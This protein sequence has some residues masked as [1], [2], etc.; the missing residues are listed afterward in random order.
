MKIEGIL[1]SQLISSAVVVV[2]SSYLLI[3]NFTFTFRWD[4]LKEMLAYSLPLIL[5]TL[6]SMILTLSD[7]YII[8]YFIDFSELG[9]YSLGTKFA[10]LINVFVLQSFQL[11]FLPIAFKIF[12]KPGAK[13]FLAKITTYMVLLLAI[14]SLVI[15]MFSREIIVVASSKNPD[16]WRASVLIPILCMGFVFKGIQY[17]FA[18]N[19]HF[20]KKTYINA[21]VVLLAALLNVGLNF[22]VIPLLGIFGAA[23]STLVSYVF[24]TI[25]FYYFAQKHFTIDYEL[26]R[27]L[28]ILLTATGIYLLSYFLMPGLTLVNFFIKLGMIAIFPL[29]LYWLGF[30]QKIEIERM[31]QFWG[32]WKNISNFR[33]NL[34]T[35]LKTTDPDI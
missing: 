30:Y 21:I 17:M 3:R 2:L 26:S 6:S 1:L 32:K 18:I 11:G 28:V 24:M 29:I 22:I 35:L 31:K 34:Q 7:R 4:I 8:E 19:L 20:V 27:A 33:E 13:S 9:I 16:F 14:T 5:S 15:S 10:G 12:D 23:L 25:A